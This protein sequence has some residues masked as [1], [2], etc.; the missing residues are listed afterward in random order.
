MNTSPFPLKLT[1]SAVDRLASLLEPGQ[2][3][4]V[5]LQG[6]GCAGLEYHFDLENAQAESD[7]LE[8]LFGDRVNVRIDPVSATYLQNAELDY[9]SQAFSSQFVVRNPQAS[10]TCGCGKSFTG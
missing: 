4:R 9:E 3:L 1:Q 7:D 10:T 5:S 6:G 8:Q 2:A